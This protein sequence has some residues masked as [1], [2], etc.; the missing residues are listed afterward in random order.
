MRSVEDRRTWDMKYGEQKVQL[1]KLINK[2]W[3]RNSQDQINRALRE[4]NLRDT[5][6][7][8]WTTWKPKTKEELHTDPAD[9][10]ATP[11]ATWT[12]PVIRWTVTSKP[13]E[14]NPEELKEETSEE[15]KEEK[16]G[17]LL[18]KVNE[19]E[20]EEQQRENFLS[21]IISQIVRLFRNLW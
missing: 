5:G 6:T 2:N 16:P 17:E 9:R 1:W 7:N 12:P 18:K 13:K 11:A 15:P 20:E 8:H 4:A 3:S 10:Q 14:E 19:A 21:R